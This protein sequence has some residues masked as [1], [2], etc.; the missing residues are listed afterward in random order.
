[1]RDRGL[2]GVPEVLRRRPW[3]SDRP[4]CALHGLRDAEDQGRHVGEA[5]A[6]LVREAETLRREV[7]DAYAMPLD[8]ACLGLALC[9]D[10]IRMSCDN[11]AAF[12]AKAL[13]GAVP[14]IASLLK[15]S[16]DSARRP[17]QGRIRVPGGTSPKYC[18]IEKAGRLDLFARAA[19][20][21]SAVLPGGCIKVA[22]GL[23]PGCAKGY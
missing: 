12:R 8:G 18:G 17:A 16:S 22:R 13:E 7:G 19:P 14:A 1:M 11:G 21:I 2:R 10:V 23:P 15:T 3:A 9:P 20:F 4:W 6:I 5:V